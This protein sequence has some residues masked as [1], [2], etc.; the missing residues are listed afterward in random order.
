M[1]GAGVT[2]YVM[3]MAVCG[4]SNVKA[5]RSMRSKYQETAASIY[6]PSGGPLSREYIYGAANQRISERRGAALNMASAHLASKTNQKFIGNVS[7]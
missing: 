7:T 5:A 6:Q 4:A 2:A 3:R 1:R